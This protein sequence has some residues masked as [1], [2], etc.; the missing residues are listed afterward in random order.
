MADTLQLL[1]EGADGSVWDLVSPLSPVF[2]VSIE[3]LGLPGFTNQW[4]VSGARDGQRYEGTQWHAN[5]VTMVVQVGDTYTA[6]GFERR[7]TGDDWRVLDQAWRKSLSA[8]QEGRLVVI[9][10]TGG[11]R[12][13]TL[14]LESKP[15]TPS[16]ANPA[17]M[18]KALY[19][20]SL[21]A[22]ND[23]W[24][25]GDVIE[26]AYPWSVDNTPFFDESGAED[27]VGL[28]IAEDAAL[29]QAQIFN[30]GD[31]ET[32]PLWW[33]QG[34]FEEVHI[35]VGDDF[36]ILP[37]GLGETQRVYV[38]SFEQSITDESG[39]NLWPL[40]G[41]SDPLFPAIPATA[42][43]PLYTRLV[44]AGNGAAIG[45]SIVPR[46]EGPW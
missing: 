3:G 14:R 36:A 24:W 8:E 30:P 13:L 39:T 28:Y 35:G 11:R 23:P 15:T 33:A 5:S 45:V 31:R 4:T 16:D 46:Y 21:T 18:G 25:R 37:F 44:D 42:E 26:V 6:P 9:T 43:A 22:G 38:D 2:A 29:E 27:E 7:R 17:L 34:P 12:Y 10:E 1:W 32:Y 40:M 41:H 20:Y 19:V